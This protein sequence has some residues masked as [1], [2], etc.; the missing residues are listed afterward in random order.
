MKT[1]KWNGSE[2]DIEPMRIKAARE[3]FSLLERLEQSQSRAEQLDICVAMLEA[4]NCPNEIID[5]LSIDDYQDCLGA[6]GEAHWPEADSGN[7]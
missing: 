4:L 1:L 3:Y 7:P 2:Y 6:L 5:A